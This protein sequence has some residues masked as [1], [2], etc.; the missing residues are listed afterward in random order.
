ML[1]LPREVGLHPETGT[2]I[3]AGLGRY[4]P[5][6]LH[7]GTYANLPSVEEVFS[8]GINRA[9]ALLAEKKAGGGKSRFQRAAPTVL[10]ELGEHPE[11]GGKVQVLSGRY[12]PYVKHGDVNATL[13][14]AK[15]PA[16]LTM[17]EA[18]QLIAERAAKGPSKSKR[19][20][21][22]PKAEKPA[23]A[24]K[25]AK[26]ETN[27]RP[28]PQP[29]QAK[30]KSKTATKSA[31][32]KGQG[33]RGGGI[34]I[35]QRGGPQTRKQ[36]AAAPGSC[37]PGTKFSRFS[38]PP[39]AR[40]ASVR[41]RATS[42]SRATTASPS[43]ALLTEMADEGLLTGNRK[44]FKERGKL[45]PVAVLEIMA[46]DKDGELVAEPAVWDSSEGE[47]PKVLVID[48][49]KSGDPARPRSARAIAFWR[50]LRA[51]PTRT[52]TATATRPSRSSAC[53]ARSGAMLG[54]FRTRSGGG[55]VIDPVDRKELKEWRIAAGDEGDAKDGDLVRFDLNRSGRFGVSQ[56]R[57]AESLGNPQD[58]RKVS[59][60]AVH[61]H[62]IP[63]E[64]PEGVLTEAAEARRRPRRK[65]ASTC[66][67]SRCSPSTQSMPA[68][69]TMPCTR[70]PTADPKNRDGWIVHVAIADVA[71]YVRPGSR[72]D[73]EARIRGNSV[74][75]PDRVVPMLPE[76]ISN[77]LCSLRER[78]VRRVPGRTHG[79]R[80]AW[81]QA[82]PHVP[83]R[84]DALR[85]QAVLPGGAGGHRRPAER[86]VPSADAERPAAAMGGL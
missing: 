52:S 73:R 53:R 62:G 38:K 60:I 31:E 79:I 12:G 86:E 32:A 47:R 64:F 61:A 2:P 56:A 57:V 37:R 66:A 67:I 6:I 85:R 5:F 84:P 7:D 23:K 15:E 83:A 59:L 11:L 29:R 51:S 17:D 35:P 54:I 1:R 45:P 58:Q 76:R 33:Q 27:P 70:R 80:Q 8:V 14:R 44:G 10:K 24:D 39:A 81:Q 4:G 13:P 16:A 63:D 3:T 9:V 18:V 78:E 19:R 68:T 71:Y 21:A 25:P 48:S 30:P 41:S 69:M 34:R 28:R 77:D 36:P 72:M 42:P 43:R 74:Y 46:R 22:K 40:P 26:A 49:K 20:S 55:G 75:F 50:A 65:A 82:Q